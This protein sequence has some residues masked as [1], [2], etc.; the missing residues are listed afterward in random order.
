MLLIN[1]FSKGEDSRSAVCKCCL[2][3]LIDGI[4]HHPHTYQD[5]EKEKTEKNR[6]MGSIKN[7]TSCS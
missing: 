2:D 5:K 7:S 3:E 1:M 6:G 4:M